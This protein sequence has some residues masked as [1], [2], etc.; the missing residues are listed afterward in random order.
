MSQEPINI[1]GVVSCP[2]EN[3]KRDVR[4]IDSNYNRLFNVPDGGNIILTTFEGERLLLPCFYI[5]DYHAKIGRV[6]HICEFAEIQESRGSVYEPEIPK[7]GDV[8]D[9][10]EIF[11]IKDIAATDYA[12]RPYAEAAG[13]LNPADYRRVYAGMY[14]REM[15]LEHLW[16]K[17]NRDMRPFAAEMRSMSISDIVVLTRNGRKTAHYM[18]RIGFHDADEFL[19]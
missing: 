13:K 17:H 16:A 15:T 7:D 10:Y 18:D 8:F 6:Y 9:T 1:E 5:D 11:Q 2:N 3:G 14:A 12:F 4:F 19:R